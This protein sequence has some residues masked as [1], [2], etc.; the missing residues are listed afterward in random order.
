MIAVFIHV[1]DAVVAVIG[2][3][4]IIIQLLHSFEVNSRICQPVNSDVHL[5]EAEVNITFE[6]E[7]TNCFVI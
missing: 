5:G 2:I 4:V 3:S 7:C 6:K 1:V